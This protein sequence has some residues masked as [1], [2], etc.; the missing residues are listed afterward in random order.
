MSIDAV[1]SV[2]VA[3]CMVEGAAHGEPHRAREIL[4]VGDAGHHV[5]AA[6]ALRVLEGAAGDRCAGQQVDDPEDDGGRAD[7]DRQPQH[8]V[9]AESDGL[10][11]I[12][13]RGVVRGDD[14]VQACGRR[15]H[16]FEDAQP[17]TDD[18]EVD[19]GRRCLDRG[20]AGE[21][22]AAFQV[23]L[24]QRPRREILVSLADLDHALSAAAGPATRLRNRRRH[25]VGVVE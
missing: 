3:Q 8:M 24:R 12:E 23:R 13:H 6:E 14:G 21:T 16:R 19:V 5:A 9:P 1:L 22:E 2:Q 18:R 20:L 15:F 7:V 25:L 10:V 11:P 17:A 4:L